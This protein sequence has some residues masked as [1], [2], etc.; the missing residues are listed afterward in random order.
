[1]KAYEL[2]SYLQTLNRGWVDSEKTVDTFK[3]GEPN[4][5]VQGIAV[6]WM[7]YTW[8]LKKAIDLKCN[9]FVTH[10]PTYYNHYDNKADVLHLPGVREK[11]Q[12]IE[13]YGLIVLR[14]HDLWDQFPEIGIPDTWGNVL[15]L[16]PAI[17]GTGFFRIY[18]VAGK[19]AIDVAG[20][21]AAQTQQFGQ[22]AVQLIGP[23]DKPVTRVSIGTGAI[24]PFFKFISA[25]Q[26]DLAICTD[27]GIAYWRD[28]AY[29]IDM[30]LP[31]IVVNHAVSEEAGLIS[32][33]QHLRERFPQIPIHHIP[34]RS[35]Y[36]LITAKKQEKTLSSP[37]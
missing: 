24:T 27:D 28:G 25:Y 32:L 3:S 33:A 2:Q 11:Q 13:K 14:C 34:Q 1:M 5:E 6:A 26:V 20:Q 15:N 35:M 7:S 4:S 8:A 29:A 9:V 21:V 37:F 10:E 18:D 22:D 16:G 12:F 31:L 23:A 17:D 36:K 19:T 30:N